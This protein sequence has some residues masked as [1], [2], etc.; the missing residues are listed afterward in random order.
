MDRYPSRNELGTETKADCSPKLKQMVA[1]SELFGEV[2]SLDA[3]YQT[4][5]KHPKSIVMDGSTEADE[6]VVN[7]G[8]A[9]QSWGLFVGSMM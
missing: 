5:V 3:A 1:S 4:V 8:T 2:A 7:T 6:T 9:G